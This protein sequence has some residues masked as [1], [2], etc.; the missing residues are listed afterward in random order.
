MIGTFA[1]NK[2]LAVGS[3]PLGDTDCHISYLPLAHV[4]EQLL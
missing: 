4:F 1:A 3:T 2:R